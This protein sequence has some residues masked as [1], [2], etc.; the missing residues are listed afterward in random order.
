MGDYYQDNYLEYHESTVK[1][2][3]SSFLEPVTQRLLPSAVI[4]DVGCGSGRDMLW[5]KQRGFNIIGFERSPGLTELAKKHSGCQIIEDDFEQY[6]FSG[7]SVD[8][9]I[10][11]GALVH[12]PHNKFQ[13]ALEN[14][15]RG[16]KQ[17]G[18]VLV[19]M[20][21]NMNVPPDLSSERVFYLW[22]DRDLRDIFDNL[23]LIIVDFSRQ[24]SK[25]RAT[26]VW[27]GYVLQ[28]R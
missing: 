1:I 18:H 19:T 11:V 20:K 26:D 16:L 27:L 23:N 3:P 4:L 22:H 14:I 13:S 6:D 12:V 2:D 24:E 5:L 17:E 8:A 10:L 9:I 28:K 25:I 21:E 7:L 15:V